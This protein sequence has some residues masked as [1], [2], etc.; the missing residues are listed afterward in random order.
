MTVWTTCS[1]LWL[2]AGQHTVSYDCVDNMQG[3][4]RPDTRVS[5]ADEHVATQILLDKPSIA[6]A[7]QT[8]GPW[9]KT[10]LWTVNNDWPVD[11]EQVQSKW[12]PPPTDGRRWRLQSGEARHIGVHVEVDG[13]SRR[14]FHQSA[15]GHV[16]LRWKACGNIVVGSTVGAYGSERFLLRDAVWQPSFRWSH[17]QGGTLRWANCPPCLALIIVY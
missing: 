5:W 16:A 1:Q 3:S 15:H 7:R 14:A 17:W 8:C 12:W 2:C 11:C 10:D 6:R 9:T 13:W 4:G